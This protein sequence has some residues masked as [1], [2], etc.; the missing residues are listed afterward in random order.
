M[1]TI[2]RLL[3][4]MVA[5]TFTMAVL[6]PPID[7]LSSEVDQPY[8]IQ[9]LKLDPISSELWE[10]HPA[11][12]PLTGD[13]WFVRSNRDFSGWRI[14][15]SHC[16]NGVLHPPVDSPVSSS[17]IEADPYFTFDGQRLYYISSRST[18][19]KSSAD[20][21]IWVVTRDGSGR[22]LTPERLPEPVNS[23]AAEWFPR[24]AADGWLYF[25]SHR[26]GG[27]GK[28]DI[29]RAKQGSNGK[30]VVENLGAAL[31]SQDAEYEFLP[32]PNGKWGLLSTD[33]GIYR[34][35]HGSKGWRRQGLLGKEINS[36]GTEIGPMFLGQNG[37]FL[38]SRDA[39]S[40]QS[41]ELFVAARSSSPDF[42]TCAAR[43]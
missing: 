41:G 22:W 27:F 13:F 6:Q 25:G 43:R 11:I 16:V 5:T 34:V 9:Q 40:K 28:D 33:R 2:P 26:T 18:G 21:D 17:G 24:P 29:W 4:L 7:S 10:S 23:E 38:F 37:T 32:A 12:D 15:V 39:G 30:W 42:A 3:Y 19:S 20:L 31:N 35:E 8:I 1:F 14:L 36:T